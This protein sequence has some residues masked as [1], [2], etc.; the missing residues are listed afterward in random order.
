MQIAL[1]DEEVGAQVELLYSALLELSKKITSA[2]DPEIREA[3][4]HREGVLRRLLHRLMSLSAP[5][6]A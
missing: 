1:N 3:L 6:A 2:H 4:K 5:R